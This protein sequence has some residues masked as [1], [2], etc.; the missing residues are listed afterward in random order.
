MNHGPSGLQLPKLSSLHLVHEGKVGDVYEADKDHL[1]LLRSDRVSGLN[2][3]CLTPMPNKGR[4]LNQLSEW[5][6]LQMPL[7][8]IVDTHLSGIS[9]EEVLKNQEDIEIAQGRATVVKKLKPIL[10]EAVV[11][12]HITGSGYTAY[13]EDGKICGIEL[14]KGLKDGDRLS[15]PIFTPT[16]KS[17]KD[18][19][20]TFEQMKERLGEHE[21]RTVRHVSLKLFEFAEAYLLERGIILADTKFEFGIDEDGYLTLM[22]EVFTPDSSRLWLLEPYQKEGKIVS[23]DKQKIRD[24]MRQMEW[25]GCWDGKTPIALPDDLVAEVAADYARIF[26]LI[27]GQ[28]PKL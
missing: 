9:L 28:S 5:W 12:R 16:E 14:P 10:V 27:T 4:I 15:E 11:R 7:R 6:M 26:E 1:L 25:A 18:P 3:K 2:V 22:D 21:A 8:R 19:A 23:L 17:D 20:I 24:W 13:L